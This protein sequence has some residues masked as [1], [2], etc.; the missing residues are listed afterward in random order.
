M[1]TGE[2]TGVNEDDVDDYIITNG[3]SVKETGSAA[4]YKQL[5]KKDI[6]ISFA[7]F[8]GGNTDNT[9]KITITVKD[10]AGAIELVQMHT[11]T[12]NT[13]S[14]SISPYRDLP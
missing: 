1:D 14:V 10:S 12:F 5:Y 2:T 13:G 4:G 7:P 3:E 6:G 9:K 8:N 11:Y